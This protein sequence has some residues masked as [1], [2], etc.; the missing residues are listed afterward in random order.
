MIIDLCAPI[1]PGKSAA[2]FVLYER[3]PSS[4]HGLMPVKREVSDIFGPLD[5]YTVVTPEVKIMVHQQVV[6]S[7]KVYSGYVGKLCEEVGVGDLL[8]DLE[9]T[10]GPWLE[11][12]EDNVVIPS[13]PGVAIDTHPPLVGTSGIEG[14][15]V[16]DPADDNLYELYMKEVAAF[17]QWRRGL[18]TDID[19][20]G[21]MMACFESRRR[22]G[23]P[24]SPF[25]G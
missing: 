14:F 15:A 7:I 20:H 16:F 17:S 22:R 3:V 12:D 5:L 23:F 10:V 4:F 25:Q 8:A 2:G 11:D 6:V 9:H 13:L 19:Y 24:S 1:I 18:S 21:Q